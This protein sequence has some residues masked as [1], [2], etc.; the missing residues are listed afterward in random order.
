M[1]GKDPAMIGFTLDRDHD[2][3]VRTGLHCSPWAHRTIGTYPAGTIRVSPGWFT[4]ETE[5]ETFLRAMR[6]IVTAY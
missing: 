2:I 1:D 6:Q 5:I 4:T 3:E